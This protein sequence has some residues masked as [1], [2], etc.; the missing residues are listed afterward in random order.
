MVRSSVLAALGLGATALAGCATDPYAELAARCEAE[1]RENIAAAAA[2]GAVIGAAAGAAA[3]RDDA[4]GAAVGGAAGA[5]IGAQ[6]GRATSEDCR[7]YYRR[8]PEPRRGYRY[9]S[10]TY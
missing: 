2:A 3:D 6:I 1:R 7:E 5:L 10:P 4:R 9:R 8:Y